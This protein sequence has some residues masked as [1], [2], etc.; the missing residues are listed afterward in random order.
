MPVDFLKTDEQ[1]EVPIGVG[2]GPPSYIA[3]WAAGVYYS[4]WSEQVFPKEEYG[5]DIR[6]PTKTGNFRYYFIDRARAKIA[7]D[8][9]GQAYSPSTVWLWMAN[10]DTVLNWR[11]GDKK[12]ED[13][14]GDIVSRETAYRTLSKM[15][16]KTR[17]ELHMISLPAAI[18]AMADDHDYDNPGFSLDELQGA[19]D[20]TLWTDSFQRDIVGNED[21]GFTSSILWKRRAALWEAL[22]ENDP[23]KW[24][25]TGSGIAKGKYDTEAEKLHNCLAILHSPWGSPIWARV[26]FVWDPRVD[27]TFGDNKR[28]TKPVLVK[29][30]A[31]KA[32]AQAAASEEIGDTSSTSASTPS[33]PTPST[34]SSS[35][36]ALPSGY[37]EF[38]DDWIAAVRD[39][40]E[41]YGGKLPAPPVLKK[42]NVLEDLMVTVGDLKAWWEVV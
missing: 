23:S 19:D 13:V 10:T 12:I 8:E 41:T 17:H 36:P 32:A 29:I 6:I 25:P 21:V 26:A 33:T 39:L 27:A 5:W 7:Y 42:D 11:G 3:Q 2:F 1:I 9:T 35:G 28:L 37:E 30:F 16:H 24:Q 20:E 34:P 38:E 18:A 40:K 31:N 22:G 14:F 15:A 4:F